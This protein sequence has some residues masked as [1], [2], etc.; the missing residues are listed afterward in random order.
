MFVQG[1]LF[2]REGLERM[3]INGYQEE[4]TTTSPFMMMLLNKTSR[5]DVAAQAVRAAALINPRV[6]IDAHSTISHILHRAQKVKDYIL[7][8]GADPED[9]FDVPKFTE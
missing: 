1:L 4:G 3:T 6:E 2:G 7:Q 5:Y 8:H 9:T